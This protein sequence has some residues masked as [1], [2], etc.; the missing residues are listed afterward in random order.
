MA[1]RFGIPDPKEAFWV[2]RVRILAVLEEHG[3][4]SEDD[5]LQFTTV[6]KDEKPT[7]IKAAN[8]LVQDKSIVSLHGPNDWMLA[9]PDIE[10]TVS[11][12]EFN[13]EGREWLS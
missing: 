11:L 2:Y 1:I 7:W 5:V 6:H 13:R 4:L 12:E 3:P 10:A 9:L 8:S